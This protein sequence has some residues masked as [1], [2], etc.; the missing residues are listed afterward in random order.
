MSSHP[1][2]ADGR[3]FAGFGPQADA[4]YIAG[5]EVDKRS[6]HLIPIREDADGSDHATTTVHLPVEVADALLRAA[7]FEFR[8]GG[9]HGYA[10]Y[11]GSHRYWERDEAVTVAAAI[12][13][14]IAGV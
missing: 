5:L 11:L 4:E 3:E 14:D 9:Y 8:E 13:A 2:S 10:Y 6:G 12:V 1:Q 7:G